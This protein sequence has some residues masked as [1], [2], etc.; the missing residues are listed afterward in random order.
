MLLE[1]NRAAEAE[2]AYRD[3]LAR[4]SENGWAL[5]GL[6]RALEAQGK[7]ADAVEA[8]KRS[9]AAWVRADIPLTASAF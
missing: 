2:R 9:E 5:F 6:A 1:A 3:D 4:Y 8:R 7:T